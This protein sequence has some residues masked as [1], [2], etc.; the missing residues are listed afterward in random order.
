MKKSWTLQ[1][2][3]GTHLVEVERGLFSNKRTIRVDGQVVEE[4]RFS[5]FDFGGDYPF[6]LGSQTAILHSRMSWLNYVYDISVD[7]RS[8]LSSQ[9]VATLQL[10]PKWAWIFIAA[11][12]AIPVVALGGALPVLIG[13]GG[14][15]LC[16]VI[17]RRP[18]MRA[19]VSIGLAAG[20]TVVSWALFILVIA[21]TVG[22]RT[23]LT[24]TQTTWQEFKSASGGFTVQM[25]GAPQ[26]QTQSI[27]SAAG[28]LDL[29]NFVVEDRSIAY[30]VSYLDFPSGAITASDSD[31]LLD[32]A[33]DGSVKSGSGTLKSKSSLALGE[34]PGR[35][36]EFTTAANGQTPATTIRAHYFLVRTRLYQVLAVAP[37]D[38][39]PAE[40]DTFLNSFKLFEQ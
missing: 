9:P 21:T 1:S 34:Y 17:A 40:A 25:P 24:P 28:P 20:V 26:E 32:N 6:Q 13:V 37:Q 8:V 2:A 23:L 10:V 38:Q 3:D 14:A 19:A 16:V 27:A 22:L 11:C 18:G 12:F 35:L 5:T 33:V 39:L 29:H 7:G 36:A 15:Y 31:A 4:G 30:I